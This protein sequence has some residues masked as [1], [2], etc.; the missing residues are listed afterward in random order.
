MLNQEL[1]LFQFSII[2]IFD[3]GFTIEEAV[4]PE[5]DNIQI[6]YGMSFTFDIEKDWIEYLITANF[7][8]KDSNFIFI[9]GT[10]LTRFNV[11]NLD[12]FLDK[13]KKINFPIGS[14]ESLFG[15]AFGHLRAIV[16]K[17]IVGSKFSNFII[18]VINQQS[19]FDELLQANLERVR[20]IR[21]AG[22]AKKE[23]TTSN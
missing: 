18:P 5:I 11:N 14:L 1:P 12:G 16:S 21:E 17:N 23:D 3:C 8:E 2:R 22:L 20:K 13:N 15:I 19:L 9:T 6:G 7:K 4:N 10:V